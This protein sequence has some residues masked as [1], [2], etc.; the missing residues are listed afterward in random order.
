MLTSF[1]AC[2]PR[3]RCLCLVMMVVSRKLL[4]RYNYTCGKVNYS[5]DRGM[6]ETRRQ[7]DGTVCFTIGTINVYGKL[8]TGE[9][10]E[11]KNNSKR[12]DDE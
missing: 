4:T 2:S 9:D 10:K 11:S 12:Q 3:V 8:S 5:N 1:V 6:L 7:T